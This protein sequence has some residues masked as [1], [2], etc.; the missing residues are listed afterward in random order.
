[1]DLEEY[2][3]LVKYG[4]VLTLCP[5]SLLTIN[6]QWKSR[7]PQVNEWRHCGK[8]L[9]FHHWNSSVLYRQTEDAVSE[10]YLRHV[11]FILTMISSLGA[12]NLAGFALAIMMI[13]PKPDR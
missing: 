8:D 11:V 4:I 1:M 12:S 7:S 13:R 9:V 2:K 5:G 3:I 10:R 6:L